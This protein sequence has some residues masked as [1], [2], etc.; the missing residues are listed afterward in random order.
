[1]NITVVIDESGDLGFTKDSSEIFLIAYVITNEPD[2]LRIEIKR[3]LKRINSK[4]NKSKLS[5]FKFSKDSDKIKERFFRHIKDLDFDIGYVAVDKEYVKRDK[6]LDPLELYRDLLIDYVRKNVLVYNPCKIILILDKL[7]N[8]GMIDIFDNSLLYTI[9]H[10]DSKKEKVIQ[11][12][13]Y[14]AGAAFSKI[15]H[16]DDR[17]YNMIKE[18]IKFKDSIGKIEW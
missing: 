9:I 17:Y 3:L 11:L 16:K 1:M 15:I 8:K 10:E 5:E 6:P 12:A 13:D 2:R 4:R 7:Y 18:R 14:I